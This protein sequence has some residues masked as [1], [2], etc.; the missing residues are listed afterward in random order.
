MFSQHEISREEHEAW[1]E[2]AD[3]DPS[4]Q[5]LVVEDSDGL[6]GFVQ[7]DSVASKG[8]AN[9]G[10]YVRPGAPRGSGRRL[11]VAALD[12]AFGELSLH[13]LCGQAIQ[14]NNASVILH[15]R[16]GFAEEG[17]LREQKYANGSYHSL[18][19]FG[20]LKREWPGSQ[21]YWSL[22]VPH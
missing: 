20:M 22:N 10:F 2:A 12:H 14:T 3:S 15:R 16:L 6:F 11:G 4:R 21:H 13:K 8:I 1:F 17:V 19:C 9:W 18:I 7:L 5:L